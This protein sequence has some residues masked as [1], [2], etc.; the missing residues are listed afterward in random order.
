MQVD[1]G[2][3]KITW[4]GTYAA[5][6]EY[7]A[8]D[9]VFYGGAS[10]ICVAD[11]PVTGTAP[12][13]GGN[14]AAWDLMAA[15]MP[16][17]TTQGQIVFQGASGPVSLAPGTSGYMLTTKGAGADPAWVLPSSRQNCTVAKLPYTEQGNGGYRSGG[18]IMSDGSLTAWGDGPAIGSGDEDELDR[19]IPVPVAF[20]K[21]TAN[22]VKWVRSH[23]N[24]LVLFD[25]GTVW[26]WGENTHGCLGFNDPQYV[27]RK[28][29]ALNGVN[30]VDVAMGADH[31]VAYG[32]AAFLA[33]DG[34]L[35]TCGYNGYG[36]LGLGDLKN[37]SVPT[38]LTKTDWASIVVVGTLHG[39]MHG[40]DTAGT[41]WSWGY[42]NTGELGNG[43]TK[44]N[45]SS[46]VQ[47]TLPTTVASV[48][49]T[50]I[51]TVATVTVGGH[52]IC[53]LT[54]GRVYTW[55][56]NRHGQLGIG[57]NVSSGSPRP[58]SSLGTDNTK[59]IAT[60]GNLG[61]SVVQK[62]GGTIRVFGSNKS[63][64][65]G[66]GEKVSETNAPVN[67][68]GVSGND[69][70]KKLLTG[71]S[72]TGAHGWTAVLF[73]NGTLMVCG[74]NGQGQLGIGTNVDA[75]TFQ[76]VPFMREKP[77]D[78]CIV[79]QNTEAG[80][81]IL[82]E[83]GLYYQTGFADDRQLPGPDPHAAQTPLLVHF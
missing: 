34:T 65:L 2:K 41:L 63:G 13:V 49:G 15:G 55:G 70:I 42:Q 32:F 73:N 14:N 43:G 8:D 62:T 23:L 77:V 3:I 71:G 81:G 79:G 60:G 78:I 52:T 29:T 1:L 68:A 54:D 25:D 16:T 58:V 6:T 57:T 31:S 17:M 20:P 4:K 47:V 56:N 82:T 39:R 30:I 21:I 10:Y 24:N 61:Y 74:Y 66:V 69:G 50:S 72:G 37:R 35:Y 7:E 64:Q 18:A 33:D 27:P 19:A 12:T 48:S 51:P 22:T 40:I 11:K 38:A 53:L 46:P 76:E 59:V 26:G 83:N 5:A 67:P 80:L 75:F 44:V 28:V 45:S 9:A 36:Q